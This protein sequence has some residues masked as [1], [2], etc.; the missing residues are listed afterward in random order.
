MKL[1]GA[2]GGAAL[3]VNREE[4]L[5]KLSKIDSG[6]RSEHKEKAQ[7]TGVNKLEALSAQALEQTKYYQ[8]KISQLQH[9]DENLDYLENVLTNDD[10]I[11]ASELKN[12]IEK[13][14]KNINFSE[15]E[16]FSGLNLEILSLDKNISQ[17]RKE[18]ILNEALLKIKELKKDFAKKEASY[19]E[20]ITKI[21]LAYENI[22]AASSD[23][24]NFDSL[25]EALDT[26][27][28]GLESDGLSFQ[29][30]ASQSRIINILKD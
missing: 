10:I 17:G 28:N 14:L 19:K 30:N 20:E 7:F 2:Y 13:V 15:S 5:K 11:D 18:E 1:T 26:V 12:E 4:S 9:S 24:E 25:A 6:G 29:K 16:L 22:K 23:F 21:K 3:N 8:T 27:K